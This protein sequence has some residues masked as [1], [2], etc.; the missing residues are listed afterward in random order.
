MN[1]EDSTCALSQS[2]TDWDSIQWKIIGKRVKRLQMR[3]AVK[4]CVKMHQKR[5]FENVPLPLALGVLWFSLL[6]YFALKAERVTFDI[7]HHA[8]VE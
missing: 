3:I 2:A 7:D 6:C 1:V 4:D 5:S 8:M